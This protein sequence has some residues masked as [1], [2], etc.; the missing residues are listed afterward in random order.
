MNPNP[1]TPP[2]AEPITVAEAKL[3]CRV[4]HVIEDSWL[5]RAITTARKK[6]QRYQRRTYITTTWEL[7]LDEFPAEIRLPYPPVQ[8]VTSIKYTDTDGVV[9]TL[10]GSGYQTDLYVFV[11]RIK[12]A[13]GESWPSTRDV[14]NAVIVEYVAG[15]GDAGIDVD[16][17][18]REAILK[19]V[20]H[21]Y[22]NRG[23]GLV[24]LSAAP[25]PHDV[26]ELLDEDRVMECA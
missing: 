1:K 25:L 14:Y 5:A 15:Y 2:T 18:P 26:D 21:W 22:E 7:R 6:C 23:V 4:D 13:Y 8:S 12:P 17:S 19:L 3:H 11:P 16:E 24:G 10:A 9:Q 20:C